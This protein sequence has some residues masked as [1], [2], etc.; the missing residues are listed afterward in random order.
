MCVHSIGVGWIHDTTN[1]I[2]YIGYISHSHAPISTAKTAKTAL[3]YI[4]SIDG[5][6]GGSVGYVGGSVGYV[7]GSVGYVI[8][9]ARNLPSGGFVQSK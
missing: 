1:V 3:F 7:G 6:V 9:H 8:C 4:D 5:Y 2:D